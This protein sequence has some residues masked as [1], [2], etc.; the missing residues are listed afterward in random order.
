MNI[1]AS[2]PARVRREAQADL[3]RL[4]RSLKRYVAREL[5]AAC[6]APSPLDG[7]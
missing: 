1:A 7:R 3:E 4:N 5:T 6:L 2:R